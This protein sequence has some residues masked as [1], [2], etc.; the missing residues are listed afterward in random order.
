M[1]A[2]AARKSASSTRKFGLLRFIAYLH[3]LIGLIGLIGGIIVAVLAVTTSSAVVVSDVVL[4]TG[5]TVTAVSILV[6]SVVF[7]LVYIGIGHAI[8]A[9]LS[10]EEHSRRSALAQEKLLRVNV[11]LIRQLDQRLP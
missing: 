6:T 3:V 1:A 7:A 2:Q 4:S 9:F 10:I 8:L 11:Q 5:G